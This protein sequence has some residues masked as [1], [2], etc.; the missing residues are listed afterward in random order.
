LFI[1]LSSVDIKL[2]LDVFELHILLDWLF[3]FE[4]IVDD[5]QILLSLAVVEIK[6]LT[7]KVE[8]KEVAGLEV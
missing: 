6:D 2:A 8:E 5:S 7:A 3:V 4:E 1:Q